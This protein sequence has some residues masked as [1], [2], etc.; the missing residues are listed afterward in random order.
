VFLG[1]AVANRRAYVAELQDRAQRAERLRIARELHDAVAHSI[2]TINV[3]AGAAEHVIAS[4]PEQAAEALQVIKQT[5][6]QAPAELREVLGVLRQDQGTQPR[7]PAVGLAQL[8]ALIERTRSG[9]VDVRLRVEG[10]PTSLPATVDLAAYRIIQESLTNVSRHSGS[11]AAMLTISYGRS[12]LTVAVS[13]DGEGSQGFSEGAGHGI[14]GMRERAEALGGTFS[15]RARPEGGFE[16][17]ASLP[18]D[19]DSPA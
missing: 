8:H 18:F 15:A 14:A 2:A 13:D 1:W 5:S 12:A 16:V 3:Q 10:Q 6:K 4:H 19:G 11:S 9:G 7:T 17:R